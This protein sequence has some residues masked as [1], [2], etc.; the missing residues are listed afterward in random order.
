VS[1]AKFLKKLIYASEA[2]VDLESVGLFAGSANARP[3]MHFAKHSQ[4][5]SEPSPRL[6]NFPHLRGFKSVISAL[7]AIPK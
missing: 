1:L 2:L 6:Q 3:V 7:T 4:N 5:N